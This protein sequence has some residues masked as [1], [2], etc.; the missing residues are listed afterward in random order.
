MKLNGFTVDEFARLNGWATPK[1]RNLVHRGLE[2]LRVEL[3]KR[4]VE[5]ES[6]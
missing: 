5:L 4:G 3:K 1:T 6:I 2:D